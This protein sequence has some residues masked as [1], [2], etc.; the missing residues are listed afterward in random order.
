MYHF[1]TYFDHNYINKGLALYHSL[2]EHYDNFK[3]Y[4]LC[5][6]DQ[7][8]DILSEMRLNKAVLI[9]LGEL[10]SEDLELYS[11]KSSRSP[12]EYYFTCTSPL[13]LYVLKQ[14]PEIEIISYVDSDLYF[15]SSPEPIFEEMGSNSILIISHRFP[16]SLRH[17]EIYGIYNVG[18]LSFRRDESGIACLEWWRK[19][20]IEWCYDR[21]D[22]GRFADQKYLNDWPSQFKNVVILQHKGAGLSPWNISNYKI[23]MKNNKILVDNQELIFYHFH[24]LKKK[25]GRI[26]DTN[27]SIYRIRTDKVLKECLYLPYIMILEK[28]NAAISKYNKNIKDLSTRSPAQKISITHPLSFLIVLKFDFLK[29]FNGDIILI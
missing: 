15:Y 26:Y 23:T 16:E 25:S 9:R 13:I 8:Y 4:I 21:L 17:L 18:F 6:S 5:L 2:D 28:N 3:L 29:I 11:T 10:E 14:F 1:C 20:C 19:R 7:A 22:N 12:I 24:G 27:L